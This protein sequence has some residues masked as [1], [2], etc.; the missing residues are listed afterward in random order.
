MPL[1]QASGVHSLCLRGES[2]WGILNLDWLKL[3]QPV[4][5]YHAGDTIQAETSRASRAHPAARE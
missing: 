2:G 5:K 4:V 3:N 1:A